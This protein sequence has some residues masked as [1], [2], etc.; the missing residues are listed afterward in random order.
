M[1]RG[2]PRGTYRKRALEEGSRFPLQVDFGEG[3]R[4]GLAVDPLQIC[5]ASSED[6]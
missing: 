1:P 3:L 5:F 6:G 2:L 4:A